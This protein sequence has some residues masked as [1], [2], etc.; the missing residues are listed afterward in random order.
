MPKE[1][2][3][4]ALQ[5]A[6]VYFDS[7]KQPEGLAPSALAVFYSI[8]S[9]IDEAMQDYQK[10]VDDGQKGGNIRWNKGLEG[11]TPPNPSYTPPNPSQPS[12]RGANRREEELF[13]KNNS[14]NSTMENK[15]AVPALGGGEQPLPSHIYYDEE[16]GE[17]RRREN[18]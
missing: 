2:V 17:Y 14:S 16:S 3:G 12:L 5:A 9:C 7:G 4:A 1:D 11:Y 13:Y 6:M 18:A 15:T 10:A 8:K